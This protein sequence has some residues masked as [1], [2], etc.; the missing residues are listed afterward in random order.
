MVAEKRKLPDWLVDVEPLTPEEAREVGERFAA[1]EAEM[2]QYG[3]EL[4][5]A[6]R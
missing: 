6:A 5:I 2:E 4:F 3:Y 1:R